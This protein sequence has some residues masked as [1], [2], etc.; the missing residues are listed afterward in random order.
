MPLYNKEKHVA[1]AVESVLGQSYSNIELIVIDDG[2]TDKSAEVVERFKDNRI[3][4]IRQE[5]LGVSAARNT[6]IEWSQA[7]II[8]FLDADDAYKHNFIE[9]I[10]ALSNGHPEAVAYALRYE[11]VRPLYD[12][13][14]HFKSPIEHSKL[15]DLP[16]FMRIWKYG[17]QI[18]A[19][20]MAVRKKIIIEAGGFPVGVK[21]GEDI[22]TWIRV[23]FIGPIAYDSRP[24][25]IYFLDADNRATKC[26]TPP[27]EYEFFDTLDKWII[28]KNITGEMAEEINEFKNFFRLSHAHYQI[29]LGRQTI[30][31]KILFECK[32]SYFMIEKYRLLLLSYAPKQIYDALAT[33]RQAFSRIRNLIY[34]KYLT[35]YD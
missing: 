11:V 8:A 25:S 22:D 28:R 27:A 34:K 30:G 26:H 29:R 20:S 23:L 3:K 6:G 31:R 33:Q 10:V 7:T 17:S 24:G 32:T 19:S 14:H 15:I 35:L 12:S 13:R 21:L 9:R 5:N 1:R 18:S 4:L 2:S 16:E